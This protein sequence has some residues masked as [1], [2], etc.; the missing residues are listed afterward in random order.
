MS[1]RELLD[2]LSDDEFTLVS[3]L[4]PLPHYLN[5]EVLKHKERKIKKE[6][7]K[8]V[9]LFKDNSEAT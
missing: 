8:C 2:G 4:L 9:S 6:H 7:L 1:R 3:H 5:N